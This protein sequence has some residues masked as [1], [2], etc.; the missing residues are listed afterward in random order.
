MTDSLKRT[1]RFFVDKTNVGFLVWDTLENE[2]IDVFDTQ[3]E[4][5]KYCRNS[6][7]AWKLHLEQ[8]I[9]RAVSH[10]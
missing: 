3:E 8:N 6:N 2:S 4:A 9:E 10:S 1:E 7:V 5:E